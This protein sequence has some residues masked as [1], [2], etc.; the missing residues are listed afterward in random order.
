MYLS[1]FI[2]EVVHGFRIPILIGFLTGLV[3]SFRRV[4][5][6]R[7]VPLLVY[8]LLLS[9]V[10]FHHLTKTNILESRYLF[11]LIPFVFPWAGHG[12]NCLLVLGRS[13]WNHFRQVAWLGPTRLIPLCV[14]ISGVMVFWSLRLTKDEAFQKSLGLAIRDGGVSSSDS[15]MGGG[16]FARSGYYAGIPYRKL[17]PDPVSAWNRIA[18]SPSGYVIVRAASAG[19]D[20]LVSML[21]E[22][23]QFER[24]FADR[25]NFRRFMIYRF[26]ATSSR[27]V[28]Q[29]L[30]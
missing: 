20:P 10:V 7:D 24:V 16:T 30:K 5:F 13:R 22:S 21:N 14:L 6:G 4:S 15:I 17:P 25:V 27:N 1:M 2:R 18:A 23:G 9:G 12:L 26:R 29:A 3:Y 11:S 28:A 8:T 19:S